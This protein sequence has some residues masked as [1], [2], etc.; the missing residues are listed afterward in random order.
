MEKIQLTQEQAE[1][2]EVKKNRKDKSSAIEHHVKIG[3]YGRNY[4]F[5]NNF[6][7]D[8]L[9]RLLYVPGS[10]E[11]IPQFKV[12]DWV[13]YVHDNSIWEITKD[14]YN[15]GTHINLM[16]G[17]EIMNV[18][19]VNR[20]RHATPE[21]IQEEKERRWWAEHGREVWELRKGDTLKDEINYP[22]FVTRGNRTDGG[23]ERTPSLN[24]VF[25]EMDEIKSRFKVA[26][27]VEQRLDK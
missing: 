18:V 16:N 24:C 5:L 10:Y 8:E 20:L 14:T 21:E 13:V 23:L 27:F 15:D 22:H 1:I 9:C 19:S 17:N 6:T 2:V 7:S 3:W 4:Q 25:R 11:V 26:C 12:G